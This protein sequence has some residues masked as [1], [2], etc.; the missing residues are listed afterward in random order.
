METLLEFARGPLF[1]ITFA[2][3]VLGLL[4]VLVLDLWGLI[5]A[6]RKAADKN[7]PWGFAFGK[8]L[9]WLFPIQRVGA[10]RPIYSIIS[11][12]FH[13][14][15]IVTP[16]FLF[17]HV[18]LWKAGVG[19]GWITLDKNWADILTIVTI[20]AG[21][22]LFIGRLAV[23]ESSFISRKQDYLWPLLIIAP[24]C[25][26]PGMRPVDGQSDGLPVQHAG[27]YPF[28]GTDFYSSAF[29]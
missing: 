20:V 8:T 2:L 14:G 23:V 9:G 22:M 13:I 3:M 18:S 26:R 16:I 24:F 27:T 17:A 4:R 11:I 1:R 6:V 7:I 25:N 19:F 12:I 15:M 5:E 29:Y 28:G 21:L 10:K